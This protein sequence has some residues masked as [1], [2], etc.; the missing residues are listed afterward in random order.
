MCP[1]HIIDVL[2]SSP[3]VSGVSGMGP[4]LIHPYSS[5]SLINDGGDC[6]EGTNITEEKVVNLHRTQLIDALKE[7][8]PIS[9]FGQF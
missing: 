8:Y 1:L 5:G 9:R 6:Y 3:G 2:V 7:S 4:V